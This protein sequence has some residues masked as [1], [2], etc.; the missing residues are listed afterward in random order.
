MKK[1]RSIVLTVLAFIAMTSFSQCSSSKK[2]Q[3]NTPEGIGQVFCQS[4]VAGVEGGGS[5]LNIFIPVTRADLM[6]DSVYF[7][8]KVARLEFKEQAMQF[9]GRYTS[10]FNKK[11][12]IIMSQDVKEEYGNEMPAIEKPIPFDLKDNECV[13][14]LRKGEKTKYFKITNVVEKQ[15]L[16]YPSAPPVKQ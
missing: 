8:G 15:A 10:D 3:K 4:W 11:K 12:D 9:V 1:L 6:L 14:S 2:L 7:R 16:A 13:I 5:G